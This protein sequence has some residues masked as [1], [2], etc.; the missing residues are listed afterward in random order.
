MCVWTMI[1][2]VKEG[3]KDINLPCFFDIKG[4]QAWDSFEFLSFCKKS[5]LTN[6]M[7]VYLNLMTNYTFYSSLKDNSEDF[8]YRKAFDQNFLSS[9]LFT[10]SSRVSEGL[11]NVPLSKQIQYW[12]EHFFL[13][14]HRSRGEVTLY[15]GNLSCKEF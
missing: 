14:H 7:F 15:A 8:W 9:K 3:E 5:I 12:V 13:L 6:I 1:I 10:V 11:H 4:T 2:R